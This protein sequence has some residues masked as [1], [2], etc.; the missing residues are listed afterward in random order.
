M[1]VDEVCRLTRIDRWFLHQIERLCQMEH[2]I[3]SAATEGEAGPDGSK[4]PR[5][6]N[7]RLF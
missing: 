4:G 7:G 2:E 6:E 3:F 5:L 1:T